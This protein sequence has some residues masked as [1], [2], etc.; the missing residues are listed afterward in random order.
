MK[1]REFIHG[2]AAAGLA[3]GIGRLSG[4][5]EKDIRPARVGFIGVGGRGSGLLRV[6]L[7][8]PGTIVPAVCDVY[9]AR[10][11][12]AAATYGECVC[13]RPLERRPRR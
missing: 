7:Q 1:R 4:A 6:A 8:V 3:L 2:T 13:L 12:A 11:S 9:P 10:A 5:A